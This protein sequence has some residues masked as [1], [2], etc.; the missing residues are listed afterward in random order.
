MGKTNRVQEIHELLLT[1][2]NLIEN[3]DKKLEIL[4]LMVENNQGSQNPQEPDPD[5]D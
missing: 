5:R 3:K 1:Q 4:S 2:Y